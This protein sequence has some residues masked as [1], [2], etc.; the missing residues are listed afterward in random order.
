MS[1]ASVRVYYRIDLAGGWTDVPPLYLGTP[2][3]VL[4][5]SLTK[6][7]TLSAALAPERAVAVAGE[8][9]APFSAST[10]APFLCRAAQAVGEV[11]GPWPS[12][13][14]QVTPD[15]PGGAG[16][17]SSGALLGG[18]VMLHHALRGIS[19][20]PLAAAVEARKIEVEKLGHAAGWQDPIAACLGG[21]LGQR[22]SRG[23]ENILHL[24]MSEAFLKN[25]L[26]RS[27]VVVTGHTRVSGDVVGEVSRR[28]AEDH[29]PTHDAMQVIRDAVKACVHA[30]MNQDENAL[31]AAVKKN[32]SGQ[33]ALH[34]AIGHDVYGQMQTTLGDKLLVLKPLGAGG[35]GSAWVLLRSREDV[36]AAQS[37]LGDFTT[38]VP[39]LADFRGQV[40]LEKIE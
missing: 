25:L 3:V 39:E 21:F 5:A 15:L 38:F 11:F 26:A 24:A 32:V 10:G 14:I 22:F 33:L 36:A 40:D 20:S 6:G 28:Y 16:L 7:I 18:L 4:T 23:E 19:C 27:L 9:P 37:A 17:G 35:G 29:V 2:G 34:P 1:Q 31:V 12:V 8:T 30:V 13:L